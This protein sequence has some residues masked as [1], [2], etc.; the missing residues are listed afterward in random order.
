M[1]KRRIITI[2]GPAASG[3]SS[4]ARLVADKLELP[5]VS[6]GLL[7]RAATYLALSRAQDL[8]D[9]A[10]LLSLLER[11]DVDLIA[12][13]IEPNRVQIDAEDLTAA[14]H[15]DD[16]DAAVSMVAKHK[17]VRRWVDARLR[18]TKGA[19]VVEG[20]D[21]GRAVFPEAAHKVYLTATPEARALRRVGE[22]A[23]NLRDVTAL[24]RLRD[25]RDARQLE[26]AADAHHIDTSD[27]DLDAVVGAVLAYLEPGWTEAG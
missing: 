2:D 8:E 16:V 17:G 15:T 14:L 24:L 18:E 7:Y 11:H 3:K 26:P 27:L 13:P 23:G 22:R 9:E 20:R 5:F 25:E 1:E 12:I 19:F 21:M 6:S 10:G 4:V